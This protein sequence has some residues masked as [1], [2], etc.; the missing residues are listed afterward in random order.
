MKAYRDANGLPR[1]DQGYGSAK[2]SVCPYR[3]RLR[4][5]GTVSEHTL[6]SGST[7]HRCPG[8]GKPAAQ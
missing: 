4:K 2:C 7:Q 6:Y 3:I 8:S 1:V 5:D